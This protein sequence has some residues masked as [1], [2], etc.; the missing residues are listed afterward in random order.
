MTGCVV[1]DPYLPPDVVKFDCITLLCGGREWGALSLNSSLFEVPL[2]GSLK[3]SVS[4]HG[5]GVAI[6]LAGASDFK[7]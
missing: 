1:K 2:P 5:R 4:V 6:R 7:C 3:P